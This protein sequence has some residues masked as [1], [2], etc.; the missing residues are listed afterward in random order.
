MSGRV[1]TTIIE[2][3]GQ[4]V[5]VETSVVSYLTGRTSKDTIVAA[6]RTMIEVVVEEAGYG[7]PVICTP[8][9]LMED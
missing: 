2:F 4:I 1:W 7:C 5:Y 3:M 8:E 9:E 6:H